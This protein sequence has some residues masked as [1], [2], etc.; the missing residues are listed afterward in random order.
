MQLIVDTNI[1]FSAFL[2][3][4]NTRLIFFHP[5]FEFYLPEHAL[6][7]LMEHKNVFLEKSALS[8]T[9]LDVLIDLAVEKVNVITASSFTAY[10]PQAKTIMD[11]I[12]P[13]DTPFLALALSFHNDGI[14]TQDRDFERQ[15]V[16]RV[17]KTEALLDLLR[18]GKIR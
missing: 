8:P 2:R 6:Q 1:L 17:W 18:Q 9:D 7:E 16:V 11:P 10:L 14:W 3:S 15:S 5:A 13:D 12:D 4:S